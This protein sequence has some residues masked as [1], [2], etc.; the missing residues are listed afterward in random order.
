MLPTHVNE[1]VV[2]NPVHITAAVNELPVDLF[3]LISRCAVIFSYH[4]KSTFSRLFSW[5]VEQHNH[6]RWGQGRC[7]VYLCV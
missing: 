6:G 2:C 4:D 1:V 3:K 5:R 7:I